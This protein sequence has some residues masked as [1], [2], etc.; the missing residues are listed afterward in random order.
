MPADLA[1]RGAMLD[2]N[3]EARQFFADKRRFERNAVLGVIATGAAMIAAFE[4]GFSQLGPYIFT[5][6]CIWVAGLAVDRAIATA[7]KRTR[8]Q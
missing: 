1:K 3:D 4:L 6:G 7:V 5:I 8:E 2:A